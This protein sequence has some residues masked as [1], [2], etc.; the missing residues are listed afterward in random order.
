MGH[1]W[2]LCAA[3]TGELTKAFNLLTRGEGYLLGEL[4]QKEQRAAQDESVKIL[5]WKSVSVGERT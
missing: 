5:A 4:L 3:W 1:N 2:T